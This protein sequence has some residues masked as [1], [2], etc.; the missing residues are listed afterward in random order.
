MMWLWN[1]TLQR[2]KYEVE[3]GP[4]KYLLQ[5]DTVSSIEEQVN[6]MGASL[7]ASR[8]VLLAQETSSSATP[9]KA[10]T[11]G[12]PLPLTTDFSL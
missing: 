5:I 6:C 11:T 9:A 7:R 10:V 2:W 1:L 4:E 8:D 12:Q 3:E